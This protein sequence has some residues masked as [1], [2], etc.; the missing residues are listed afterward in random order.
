MSG[1]L[2]NLI[3]TRGLLKK[4]IEIYDDTRPYLPS[5]PYYSEKAFESGF[6]LPEDHLWGPRDYF[7]GDYYKNAKNRFASETGYQGF[8]SPKSLEMFLAQPQKM[9]KDNG[10]P[11]DEYTVHAAS[12]ELGNTS[13]YIYRIGL[14]YK[15]ILK[16]FGKAEENFND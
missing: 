12:P 4:L 10:E 8:P 11:T 15:Q 16:L 9:F 7:K 6:P 3:L 13:W 1:I 5:S 14:T 2:L